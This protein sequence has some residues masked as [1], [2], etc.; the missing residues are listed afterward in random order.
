M[1]GKK[2]VYARRVLL[3][4]VMSVFALVLGAC[5]TSE[6]HVSYEAFIIE[7]MEQNEEGT[8]VKTGYKKVN[9]I[10]NVDEGK[11]H[12]NTEVKMIEDH[13]DLKGDYLKTEIIYSKSDKSKL[14]HS[15]DGDQQ[16]E[17]LKEPST[18]LV[19][20]ELEEFRSIKLTEEE[21]LRVKEHVESYF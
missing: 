12:L 14:L 11:H 4:C 15:L 8:F 18:I 3:L 6:R 1:T 9:A 7:T 20:D 16:K 19:P 13:Y 17:T 2:K 21:Q 10:T 5:G